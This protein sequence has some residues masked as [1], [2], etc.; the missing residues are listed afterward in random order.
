M[1]P[2][3]LLA[4]LALGLPLAACGSTPSDSTKSFSGAKRDVAATIEDLETAARKNKPDDVCTK[5]LAD[6]LLAA[7]KQQGTACHTAVKESFKDADSTDLTVNAVTIA[8][9]TASAKVTS[10]TGSKKKQDTLDLEKVGAG[11]RISALHG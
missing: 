2:V 10:G 8:G 11:W 3:L 7:I 5:L 6:S 4:V 9:A 1:K